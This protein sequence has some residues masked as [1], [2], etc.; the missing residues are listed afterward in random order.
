VLGV[1]L[2]MTM[3]QGFLYLNWHFFTNLSSR[4]PNEA[5]I[6]A[7]LVGT[8]W[9]MVLTAGLALPISIGT[10]IYLEEYVPQTIANTLLEIHIANLAAI[11]SILYG[12]LG[13]AL[14]ARAWK[15]LTG[16]YS[17]LSAAFVLAVII[18]PFLITATRTALRSVPEHRR[19]AG[20]AVG[21]T[22]EQVL[23]YVTL[24]AA[25]PAILTAVLMGLSQVI[26]ETAALI[27]VGAAA[28]VSFVPDLSL[29]ALQSGYTTLP[30][31][32]FYWATRPQTEFQGLAAATILVLGAIVVG[33]NGLAVLVRDLFYRR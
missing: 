1:L 21:M 24:P 11:P 4:N 33:V 6:Y 26:G 27:A 14:F 15:P 13:L 16:G 32:I 18:L 19:Q 5:G 30:T 10:A 22:R 2:V 31:Q 8:V 7:A 20:Y 3:Q 17:L 12:L 29:S 28:F 9:L 25:A 23:R